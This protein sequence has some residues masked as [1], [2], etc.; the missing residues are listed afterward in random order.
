MMI[1][2]DDHAPAPAPTTWFANDPMRPRSLVN[3]TSGIDGERELQ[4][5]RHLREHQQQCPHPRSPMIAITAAAGDDGEAAADEPAQPR[6]DR[7]RAGI[8]PSRAARRALP[9]M[10]LAWPRTAGQREQDRRHAVA[11]SGRS[12]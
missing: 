1:A 6:P 12:S 2:R 5:Q 10:V 3:V 4:A 9:V 7:A 8:P 11:E